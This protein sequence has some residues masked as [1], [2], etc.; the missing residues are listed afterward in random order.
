MKLHVI[1]GDGTAAV[2][3]DDLEIESEDPI[4]AELRAFLERTER[5][6]EGPVSLE[7]LEA[8]FLVELYVETP[9]RRVEPASEGRPRLRWERPPARYG[10]PTSERR[11]HVETGGVDRGDGFE[12]DSHTRSPSAD[13]ADGA[14][15]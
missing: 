3:H 14:D 7:S 2:I 9:V 15:E 11:E 8:E 13:G 4:S 12:P 5:A 6:R 1:D 10:P